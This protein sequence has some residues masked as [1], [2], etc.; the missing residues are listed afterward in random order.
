MTGVQ[1]CA[2]PIYAV[3]LTGH[4]N[5]K[6]TSMLAQSDLLDYLQKNSKDNTLTAAVK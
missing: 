2:L 4:I 3:S 1:T 6:K 5:L